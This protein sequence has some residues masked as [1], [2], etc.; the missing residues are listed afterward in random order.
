V[1]A[2]NQRAEYF[3]EGLF[4]KLLDHYKH[5]KKKELFIAFYLIIYSLFLIKTF[6][7]TTMFKISWP[8]IT[9]FI[10]F[11]LAIIF[12][13]TKVLLIDKHSKNEMLFS[14]FLAVC[15]L[16][17]YINT[18]YISLIAVLILILGA[19]DAPSRKLIQLYCVIAGIILVITILSSQVG[20]V[21]N[22]VYGS[23]ISFGFNYPTDFTAHIFYLVMGYCYLRK[24]KLTYPE[25][26]GILGLGIFSYVF[27]VAR[28]NAI[29]LLLTSAVF[30]YLKI[31]NHVSDKKGSPYVMNP[32]ISRI[33]VFSMPIC[34]FLF[35][36]LTFLYHYLPNNSILMTINS[37][38]STR[39]HLGST[40]LELYGIHLFGSAFQMVGFGGSTTPPEDYFF[41][42]SSYVLL[43]IRYGIMVFLAVVTIF[44]ASALRAEK[45]KDNYLLWILMLIAIQ[46]MIEHHLLEIAYN[47]FLFLIFSDT[48]SGDKD[49]WALI[50]RIKSKLLA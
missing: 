20:L 14:I 1:R 12:I 15:F 23:R 40:G 34:A 28:T 43:L 48:V 13:G 17:T 45:Q 5:K 33:L 36:G 6:L 18:G 27:C 24:E 8:D 41:L 46:C 39:L 26:A 50:N 10:L 44:V 49:E 42:D 21:E 29:C 19:K 3:Q 47:P 35:I 31:R 16:G 30:L 22:L 7:D 2:S 11:E 37:I 9:L 32:K 4:I 25:L 38:V